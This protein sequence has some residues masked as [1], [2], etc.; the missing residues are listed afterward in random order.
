MNV[1]HMHD[2]RRQYRVA[3][4]LALEFKPTYGAKEFTPALVK[5]ISSRGIRI[6]SVFSFIQ[7]ENIDVRL[8]LPH[9]RPH[10]RLN[11]DVVWKKQSGALS[12]AGIQLKDLEGSVL[13]AITQELSW[14]APAVKR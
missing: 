11:G 3:V 1:K 4:P 12:Q 8:Y 14:F 6:E 7:Y 5:N 9:A 10:I 2:K 13:S